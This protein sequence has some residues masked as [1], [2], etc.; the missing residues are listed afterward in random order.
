MF[1]SHP[2]PSSV[3]RKLGCSVVSRVCRDLKTSTT[4][5]QCR[6]D[7]LVVRLMDRSVSLVNSV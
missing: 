4:P 6:V 7:E 3:S 1:D 5:M 2:R